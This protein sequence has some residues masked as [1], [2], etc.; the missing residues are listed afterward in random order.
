[1]SKGIAIPTII[2]F[3]L[4]GMVE[5]QQ[6]RQFIMN[7]D[8]V[9][10][11]R[12][13]YDKGVT[14]VMFPTGINGGIYGANICREPEQAKNPASHFLIDYQPGNY[15]F[16][17]RA[18]RKHVRGSLNVVYNQKVYIINLEECSPREDEKPTKDNEPFGSVTFVRAK[19]GGQGAS[20]VTPAI[21][22]SLLDKAKAFRLFQE[23]Y[24]DQI[25]GGIAYRPP[26][27][28]TF[29]YKDFDIVFNEAIRFDK[30]DTVVFSLTLKNKSD[31]VIRYDPQ[32]LS[33]RLGRIIYYASS[34]DA[35]GEMPPMSAIPAFFSITGTPSGG[36]NN[37]AAEND[38]TVLLT[39]D[40]MQERP[41][42]LTAEAQVLKE[43]DSLYQESDPD[44]ILKKSQELQ[45]K[46]DEIKEE[47]VGP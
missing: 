27:L 23:Y 26:S 3:L 11:I 40:E 24:P 41:P 7:P 35:S 47:G 21:L 22:L 33:V 14:T 44:V 18:L 6:I 12:T 37:L 13:A 2:V 29:V 4:A 42:V 46:L 34:T 10:T 32:L 38:W 19:Q 43:M 31:R 20:P 5:A 30:Y 25:E 15:F 1:V 39:T 28:T 45:K 16:S 8:T 36:R 17:V 9:Y